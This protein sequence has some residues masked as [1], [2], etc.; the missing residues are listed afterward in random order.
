LIVVSGV[1]GAALSPNIVLILGTANLLAD[2][3]S[4]GASNVLAERSTLSA[5]T[6]PRFKDASRHG[7]AT[8]VGFVLAG[9]I[10]LS[11][12]L[13]PAMGGIRFP[14]ACSLAAVAL[15]GIGAGRALFSDRPWL[16]AGIEMLALGI[17]AS[18]VA[19]TVGALAAAQLG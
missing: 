4:M 11:A 5:A 19:Y 8:I 17:I 6:R 7:A 14:T 2:S 3:F 12:Y 18:A 9:L 13:V 16:I 1:A 10:P 15:F